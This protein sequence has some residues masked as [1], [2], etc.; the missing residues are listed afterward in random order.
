MRAAAPISRE[1]QG[2]IASLVSSIGFA[3]L[4]AASKGLLATV[5]A[6]ALLLARSAAI[7]A[8]ILLTLA[9]LR[10]VRVLATPAI[11]LT[12][13]RSVLFA[14]TSVLVVVA[15][16]HLPLADAIALYYM[17]PVWTVLLGALILGEGITR[18][19]ML[20]A[21]VG[22]AGAWLLMQPGSA[23]FTVW[24]L[25]PFIAGATGALQ[26][27]YARRLRGQT[28]PT[29][30]LFWGMVA[31]LPISL[32]AGASS[33][34]SSAASPILV[35]ATAIEQGLFALSILAGMVAYFF[36]AQSFQKAPARLIAPLRYLNLLWAVL[37]GWLIW[38]TVPGKL[39]SVGIVLIVIAGFI[40][41]RSSAAQS[42]VPPHVPPRSA[43]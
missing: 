35:L 27:V 23:G 38:G 12:M 3:T 21:L 36:A 34:P 17:S 10:Q 41:I 39:Q 5:D 42:A 20:A 26:D 16:K 40:C 29:G 14:T 9:L 1:T 24:S 31:M 19:A 2:I 13:V 8:L 7:I 33:G 22:L 37:L 11:G 28:H 43:P 32:L 6:R 15:L 4:D 25:F 18:S 30:L